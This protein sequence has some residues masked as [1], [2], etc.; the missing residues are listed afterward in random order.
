MQGENIMDDKNMMPEGFDSMEPI[1]AS[2]EAPTASNTIGAQPEPAPSPQIK[3]QT[4][5]SP[6][7]YFPSGSYSAETSPYRAYYDPRAKAPTPQKNKEAKKS[8]GIGS[9]IAVALIVAIT[10]SAVFSGVFLLLP[11]STKTLIKTEASSSET[12]SK[13]ENKTEVIYSGSIEQL[14]VNAAQTAGKSVVGIQT[15]FGVQSFF[16]GEDTYEGSGSGVIYREDGYIITN[17]HVIED[18]LEVDNASITVFLDNDIEKGYE[19]ELINYNIS[20][21]LAVLKI[22]KSGLPAIKRGNSDNLQTGQYVVAIGSPGGLDFIGSTTFGIVSGLNRTVA[23]SYGDMALIQT[24]AAINPGNSGGAL[25][26]SNGE[27]IGICNS[28]YVSTEIEGMGFAIPVNTVVEICDGLIKNENK[29]EPYFGVAINSN[30]TADV[31]EYYGYPAGAVVAG[32]DSGSPADK[33]GIRRSDIITKFGSTTIDDPSD[34][35]VALHSHYPDEE[36]E[37]TFFRSGKTH[38]VKAT[39]VSAN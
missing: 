32:V 36:V 24:D 22:D 12:A 34:Y 39:L 4:P 25:V 10:M 7:A 21:D 8:F 13:Q 38:T 14:A 3:P 17:Y 16:G 33:A 31:L 27:L 19:A 35:F 18:T 5:P 9:L 29:G 26:N 1:E 23:T 20:C 37:I 30:Y 2:K 28:K 6:S 15:T 11:K